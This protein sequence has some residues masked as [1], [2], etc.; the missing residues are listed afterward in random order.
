MT[1]NY[2]SSDLDYIGS[3]SALTTFQGSPNAFW[4]SLADTIRFQTDAVS[5]WLVWRPQ[6]DDTEPWKP[7]AQAPLSAQPVLADNLSLTVLS[8]MNRDGGAIVKLNGSG[9]THGIVQL[10]TADQRQQVILI[11][12]IS[13]SPNYEK[14]LTKLMGYVCVPQSFDA[15]RQAKSGALDAKRLA[16]TLESMGRV[17]DSKHFDQAALTFVNDLS[18][19]FACEAVSLSW[20]GFDGLRLRATSHSDKID[21]R[22]EATSLLEEAGQEA[23]TLGKEVMTPPSEQNLRN[24]A[25]ENYDKMV[26]PGHMFSLPM[27]NKD[28]ENSEVEL[29]VVTLERQRKQFSTAEQWALRLYCEMAIGPLFWHAQN[30]KWFIVRMGREIARSIPIALKPRSIAGRILF[31]VMILSI[32]GAMFVPVPFRLSA[33]AVLKTDA[34]AYVG[35]SYDGFIESSD[36]IL[37]STVNKGDIMFTLNTVELTLER[38]ALIAEL[39]QSNRDA[40]IRRALNQLSEMQVA[41]AKADELRAKLLKVDHKLLSA[42]AKA[43]ISGVVVEGEPAKKIGEGV[44]RGESQITIAALSPFYV[45]A[46]VSESDLSFLKY[47]QAVELTLLAR[48][49]DSFEMTVDRAIPAPEVQ[50][51]DNV[52]PVRMTTPETE[53]K[54]WLPGMTGVVK[55]SAGNRPIWWIASRSLVDYLRLLFWY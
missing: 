37:G 3:L 47:G 50:D 40:E 22:S 34:T 52:F 11:A 45:E 38:N 49:K 1:S 17:L 14:I 54:W 23:L 10:Q 44:R 33:T 25:H 27:F 13:R 46:A 24:N 26:M 55:I 28:E 9:Q 18:E 43:P 12:D 30:S 31:S 4:L 16:Q 42:E 51:A 20:R 5:I 7:L 32:I 39:A 48:P 21:R 41:L 53:T 8:Q 2:V 36:I 35:A 29:G 15:M 19:R 6:G